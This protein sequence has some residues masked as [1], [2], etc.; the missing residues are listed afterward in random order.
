MCLLAGFFYQGLRRFHLIK[1][2][3]PVDAQE[4]GKD[5]TI[6]DI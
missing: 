6:F 4:E 1:K 5:F 2:L 3:V